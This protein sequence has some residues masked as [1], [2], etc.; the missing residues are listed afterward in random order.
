VDAQNSISLFISNEFDHTLSVEVGL[1]PRIRAEGEGSDVVSLPGDFDL[2]FSLTNPS[3]LRVGVHDTRDGAI[4]DMA[5]SFGDVLDR[6]D[7]LLLS[8]VRQHGTEG[9]VSDGTDMGDFGTVL[10]VNDDA[11]ALIGL[12]TKILEAETSSIGAPSDSDKYYV[13][14]ELCSC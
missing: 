2:L 13:G 10:L 7:T 11:T 4:V 6:S 14:V 8:F 5:I 9:R 1:R 12:N 3:S